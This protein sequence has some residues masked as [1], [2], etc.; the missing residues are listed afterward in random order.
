M[1]ERVAQEA[2]VICVLIADSRCTAETNIL[3]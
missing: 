3:L 2:G 1:G